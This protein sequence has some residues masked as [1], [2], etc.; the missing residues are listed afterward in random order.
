MK[1]LKFLLKLTVAIL[2]A[3]SFTI[4]YV[5]CVHFKLCKEDK[6]KR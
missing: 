6:F 4:W 5:F 2:A 3:T 1:L